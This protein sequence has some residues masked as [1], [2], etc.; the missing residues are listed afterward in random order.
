MIGELFAEVVGIHYLHDPV[1]GV[2]NHALAGESVVVPWG[3]LADLAHRH[4]NLLHVF[5]YLHAFEAMLVFIFIAKGVQRVQ[6]LEHVLRLPH[7]LAF[8]ELKYVFFDYPF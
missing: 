1:D 4:V 5:A 6:L 3:Q 8:Q 2:L 7:L